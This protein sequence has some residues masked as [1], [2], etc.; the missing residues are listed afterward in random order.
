M[1]RSLRTAALG[2]SAQSLRVDNIANNL[3]NVNTT[4]FKKS[5]IEFQDL[6]YQSFRPAGVKDQ[7]NAEIPT[8]LQIGHGNRPVATIKNFSQGDVVNTGNALDL[9]LN[10][11]GFFQIQRPDGSIVYTRDGSFNLSSKGQIVNSSGLLLDP[12]T[13]I[14]EEAVSINVGSDGNISVL[15]PG[16]STPQE[17]GQ[18]ELAKF[19]NPAGLKSIGGNLYEA[20]AASGEPTLGTPG[21]DGIGSVLQ[22]FL[23][24]SNVEVVQEMVELIVAQRAYE[25]N[26]KAIR[27][28]E[29]MMEIANNIK[30]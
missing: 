16:E 19:I 20:T 21:S 13:S 27:T 11:E 30:R 5:T 23:E 12:E 17:V 10:G 14:P 24:K 9:S 18:I 29:Q 8:E 15:L 22:G 7:S 6:F 3:A 28:A 25:I 4:A 1:I 2:M 26:A